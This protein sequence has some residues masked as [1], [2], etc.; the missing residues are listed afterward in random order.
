MES[1]PPN[2][3]AYKQ[4]FPENPFELRIT[5][6]DGLLLLVTVVFVVIAVIDSIN[7][8]GGLNVYL[9]VRGVHFQLSRYGLAAAIVMSLAALFLG[10]IRK[11]DVTPWFRRGAYV[12]F[13]SMLLQA[14]LGF[15]LLLVYGA[16]P[17]QPEHIVYGIA[18]AACL[19]FFVFVETTAKKR[20]AMGS[21]VWGF[22]LLI[23]VVIR[24]ISTGAG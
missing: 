3:K 5:L 14:I 19:P 15:T 12:I 20:P 1:T 10:V 16:Q 11:D 21:Y 24:A 23:G 8:A 22:I 6:I 13:G 18:T 4:G 17:Y 2:R 9:V 7:A